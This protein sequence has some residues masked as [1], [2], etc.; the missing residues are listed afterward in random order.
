MPEIEQRLATQD[1]QIKSLRRE[2]RAHTEL[3]DTLASPPWKRFWFFM[4]GFRLW[5][6]GVWYRAPWNRG[7]WEY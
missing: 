2:M 7:G 6:L 3:L 1:R 5:R 4:Q